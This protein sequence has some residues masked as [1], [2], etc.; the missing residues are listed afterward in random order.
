MQR[1]VVPG[2]VGRQRHFATAAQCARHH[3]LS[4][5]GRRRV[6]VMQRRKPRFQLRA[7]RANLDAERALSGGRQTV[8]RVK[9]GTDPLAQTQTLETGRGQDNRRVIAAVELREP[10][11]QIA[12]QR[13]HN[14][15]RITHAQHCLAAQAGRADHAARG[16]RGERV[17]GVRDERIAR[18]FALHDGG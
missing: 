8:V 17:V 16:Q 10:R 15:L 11:V 7:P 12:A 1:A 14:Q 2:G 5:H 13:L 18:V 9:M 6:R 3:P 4:L